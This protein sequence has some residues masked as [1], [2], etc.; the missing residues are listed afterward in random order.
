LN[1]DIT[2]CGAD[3]GYTSCVTSVFSGSI[4]NGPL[5]TG[6]VYLVNQDPSFGPYPGSWGQAAPIDGLGGVPATPG[7]VA[8][9]IARLLGINKNPWTNNPVLIDLVNGKANVVY[10][11]VVK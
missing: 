2:Q 7:H 4:Q 1:E 5:I 9:T 11:A 6:N 8:A 10:P 3:H